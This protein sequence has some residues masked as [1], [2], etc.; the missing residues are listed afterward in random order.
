VY[1]TNAFASGTAQV[2]ATVRL[3]GHAPV[4]KV[5]CAWIEVDVG[6]AAPANY[7]IATADLEPGN[8]QRVRFKYSQPRP[9]PD[10]RYRLEVMADGKALGQAA[11]AIGRGAGAAKSS[12]SDQVK[13]PSEMLPLKR[14]QV[15]T[16]DFVQE[17]GPGAKLVLEDVAP[18][19][20][21][22]LRAEV[23]D[24]VASAD[25]HGSHLELRRNGKLVFE[26]WWTLTGA[27][28]S[29]TR[30]KSAGDE[31]QAMDPPQ[32]LWGWPLK[33]PRSWTYEPAD[34]SYQQTYQMWGP[35]AVKD[36]A[37]VERSGYVV[38]TRQAAGPSAIT[39]ERHWV[40]GV[41][42]VREIIVTALNQRLA[43]RQDMALKSVN[44]GS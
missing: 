34:H 29:A 42:L 23:S 24:T 28:L 14:G 41:G 20:D 26:E 44:A 37:G 2:F 5:S 6:S 27:G 22:K 33:T 15:W 21:G 35:V 12:V 17:A 16:Y 13:D 36:A 38:L 1:P 43:S 8:G 3:D 25:D 32:V 31:P 19:A 30:R 4:K 39:A 40:P 10:G 11:F 18:G 9:M 7:A